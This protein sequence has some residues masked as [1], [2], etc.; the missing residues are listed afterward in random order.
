MFPVT[1]LLMSWQFP[2]VFLTFVGKGTIYEIVLEGMRCR[3]EVVGEGRR[4]CQQSTLL[5]VKT[6]EIEMSPLGKTLG[7]MS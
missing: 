5:R 6:G 2:S 1:G 7:R 4:C 3:K